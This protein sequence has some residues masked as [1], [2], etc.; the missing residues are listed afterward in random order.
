MKEHLDKLS[1]DLAS[2]MTRRHALRLF[3]MG[4]GAGAVGVLSGRSTLAADNSVC[5]QLC[6]A[7]GLTGRDF[8]KCVSTSAHCPPGE[9]AVSINGGN[10]VCVPVTEDEGNAVCVELCR[11]QNL[12]E[13]DFGQCVS[14]SAHCPSGECAVLINGGN[15][16]CIPVEDF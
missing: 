10:F 14:T 15:F 11:E 1:K 9:C 13:S 3:F 5:V 6:R 12:T 4:L 16:I 8:G 2:G 7:Q